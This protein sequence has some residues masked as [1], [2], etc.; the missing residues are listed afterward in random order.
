MS[1]LPASSIADVVISTTTHHYPIAPTSVSDIK[2]ELRSQSPIKK[3]KAQFHGQTQWHLQPYYNLSK[4]HGL[5]RVNAIHIEINGVY[6][7][8]KLANAEH[9]DNKITSFFAA[10]YENLLTHEKGHE[11]LWYEAGLKIEEALERFPPHYDCQML[12]EQIASKV[13]EIIERY[14]HKNSEYDH[15]TEH[16]KTQGAFVK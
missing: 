13:T 1:I 2:Y 14:K 12:N 10:Y 16:G 7:L 4:H 9:V 8:P 11:T 5:C 3:G 15:S 6:T